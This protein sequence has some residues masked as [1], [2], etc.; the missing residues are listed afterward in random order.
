MKRIILSALI[1]VL[2]FCPYLVN[3][4]QITDL[5]WISRDTTAASINIL[6]NWKKG[7]TKKFRGK[8][9]TKNYIGDSLISERLEADVILQFFVRDSTEHEY[10]M[11]YR[12]LENLRNTS[13]D[14]KLPLEELNLNEDSLVLR[15]TTDKR[16]IVKS[17]ENRTFIENKMDELMKMIIK[18]SQEKLKYQSEGE[19][20]TAKAIAEKIANGKVLF[21]KTY[22]VYVSQ[23]HNLQG[24]SS[25]INDTLSY[26]ETIPGTWGDKPVN[27]DCYLYITSIDTTTNEVRIDTEKYADM[28]GFMNDYV[29]YLKKTAENTGIKPNEKLHDELVKMDMKVETYIKSFIDLDTGWS[30]FFSVVKSVIVKDPV[31]NVETVRDEIWTLNNVL[32]DE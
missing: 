25:G 4:Q 2:F 9:K 32:T 30:T 5:K 28:K 14:P 3:G 24:Y 31:K 19:R 29:G 21:S 6:A 22:D 23:F 10:K 15:Y 7:E 11:E 12:I 1:V 17:Y 8:K 18:N 26:I 20:E 16:G 27:F 13:G